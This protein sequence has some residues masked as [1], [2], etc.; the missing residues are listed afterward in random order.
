MRSPHWLDETS[1]NKHRRK[2]NFVAQLLAAISHC[3]LRRNAPNTPLR[4]SLKASEKWVLQ[5]GSAAKSEFLALSFSSFPHFKNIHIA[6]AAVPG[7]PFAA[8]KS[9]GG[10]TDSHVLKLQLTDVPTKVAADLPARCHLT[11]LHLPVA[12]RTLSR[13]LPLPDYHGTL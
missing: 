7:P 6:T 13:R 5:I 10:P 3:H 8:S 9:S 11:P 2:A 4:A 1:Q 12:A